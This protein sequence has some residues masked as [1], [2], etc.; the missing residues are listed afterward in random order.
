ME[1]GEREGVNLFRKKA[2]SRVTQFMN[3]PSADCTKEYV[4]TLVEHRDAAWYILLCSDP[5][6]VELANG[7]KLLLPLQSRMAHYLPESR[8]LI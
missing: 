5:G 1:R 7:E 3:E 6:T 8:S 2:A 4:S